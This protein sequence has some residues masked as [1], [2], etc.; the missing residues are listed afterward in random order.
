MC[1]VCCGP[2]TG[3]YAHCFAC[4][5]LLA[6]LK[7]PLAPVLPVEICPVPSPLYRVLM[8]YKESSIGELRRLLQAGVA[9]RLTDFYVNHQVCILAGLGGWAELI[10][11]VPSTVRP[12][13]SPL[14]QTLG[15]SILSLYAAVAGET[16]RMPYQLLHR[17]VASVGHMQA[18]ADAFAVCPDLAS[19]VPGARILLFDDTYVSGAR[20]QSAAA[21]LRQA[22]A[23]RVLIVP[24]GRVIR[25]DKSEAHAQFAKRYVD[26]QPP[27][28][29]VR[30]LRATD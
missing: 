8:G 17:T 29:C 30:C 23:R 16:G 26:R 4:R 19:K 11:P 7:A 13:P 3:G 22:G 24:L 20:S 6:Q 9:K 1:R 2:T 21:A 14:E 18:D 25:P 10:V 28:R 5:T 12:P 15:F 27:G